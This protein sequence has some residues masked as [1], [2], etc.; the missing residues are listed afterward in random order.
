MEEAEVSGEEKP[1]SWA[2]DLEGG[3]L[4]PASWG[5]KIRVKIVNNKDDDD[6]GVNISSLDWQCH[7]VGVRIRIKIAQDDRP[8]VIIEP[9]C[10]AMDHHYHRQGDGT[11]LTPLQD[12][13]K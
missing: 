4:D 6:V 12:G 9:V 13:I 11:V 5:V 10:S 8:D 2:G 1:G 3:G 7:P